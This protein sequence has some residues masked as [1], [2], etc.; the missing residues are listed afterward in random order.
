MGIET[1]SA[2]RA[3]HVLAV[4][5]A[6]CACQDEVEPP[7]VYL[8]DLDSGLDATVVSSACTGEAGCALTTGTQDC[9]LDGISPSGGDCDDC[10][11]ARGPGAFD[12]PRNGI[13]EDCK[14]GDALEDPAPCDA[15]LDAEDGDR[16]EAAKALGL[17]EGEVS[18]GSSHWG[19]IESRWLRL[20]GDEVLEDV[21]QTWLPEHFGA[22]TAREGSRLL[23]LSTGVA[24]DVDADDYTPRCDVFGSTLDSSG[25]WLGGVPPPKGFPKDSST[26]DSSHVSEGALAFNDVGLELSLRAPTNATGVAFD[27]IFYTYEY[28][29]FVC[30]AYNDFFV[31]L[32]DPAPRGFED[33]DNVLFDDNGQ[34]IGVN[35]GFLSVCRE[36]SRASEQRSESYPCPQGVALLKSTGFDAEEAS[37][38]PLADGDQDLGG[39]ATGWLH[40]EVPVVAGSLFTLH[41]LLWDTSDPLLDSTVAIDNVH[42]LFANQPTVI[43]TKPVTSN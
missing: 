28:P 41:F 26:C 7:V 16:R 5:C 18:R 43:G 35:T 32:M 17:C 10:D 9:D 40:T 12:I 22:A 6:L 39:G 27:T 11:F 42:F 34:P 33:D 20:S 15:T 23:V 25:L 36:T 24:R 14:D 29:D 37:C 8:D 2:R 38:A 1:S 21:R 30:S 13:D 31:V 4:V 19:L 3:L